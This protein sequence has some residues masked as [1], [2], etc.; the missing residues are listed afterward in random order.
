MFPILHLLFAAGI[1]T[2]IRFLVSNNPM[3][4][5]FA[6]PVMLISAILLGTS[7][8]LHSLR[9]IH[10]RLFP[11]TELKNQEEIPE[12][13]EKLLQ[14][15][16]LQRLIKDEHP[17]TIAVILSFLLPDRSAA[18]I[19]TLDAETRKDLLGRIAALDSL[20]LEVMREIITKKDFYSNTS[21]DGITITAD[22]LSQ[23]NYKTRKSMLDEIRRTAPVMG[24]KLNR[25]LI[26]FEDCLEMDD[27][28][29]QILVLNIDPKDLTMALHKIPEKQQKKILRN[30]PGKIKRVVRIDLDNQKNV[31]YDEIHAA[32]RRILA[33]IRIL[34]DMGHIVV[35]RKRESSPQ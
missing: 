27:R 18:I 21:R 32:R 14:P 26:S 16:F 11:V 6:L 25:K 34:E 28:S 24:T 12:E 33:M 35:P 4:Q 3:Q 17:Q 30:A 2:G 8:I 31:N 20:S 1:V 7:I 23:L 19:E 22:I 10:K 29:L 15:A 13:P 9:R 5:R